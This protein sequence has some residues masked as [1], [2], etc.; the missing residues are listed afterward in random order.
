MKIKSLPNFPKKKEIKLSNH[1]YTGVDELGEFVKKEYNLDVGYNLALEEVGNIEVGVPSI[2]DLETTIG[3]VLSQLL[4]K[5]EVDRNGYTKAKVIAERVH[6]LI[7]QK[8]AE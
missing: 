6:N 5:D 7:I 4:V 8:R 2:S 1:K 3:L